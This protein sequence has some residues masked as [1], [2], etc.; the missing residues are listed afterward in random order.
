MNY[1]GANTTPLAFSWELSFIKAAV[2]KNPVQI[3]VQT[4]M[5]NC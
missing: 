1:R 4:N 5:S 2:C 3:Y